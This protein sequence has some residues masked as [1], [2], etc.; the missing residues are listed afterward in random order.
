MAK[1][2]IIKEEWI[3]HYKELWCKQQEEQNNNFNLNNEGELM[4]TDVISMSELQDAL[5]GMINRKA[6]GLDEINLELFRYANTFCQL[7]FL[8]C[9][10]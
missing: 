7:R 6:E 10:I 8:L 1:L 9:F 3:G 4:D 5:K 2:N